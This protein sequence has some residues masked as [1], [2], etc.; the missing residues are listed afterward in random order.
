[1]QALK[2]IC[3]NLIGSNLS[4]SGGRLH[5]IGSRTVKEERQ[6]SEGAF[7]YVWCVRDVDTGEQFALKKMLCQD[8]ERYSLAKREISIMARL[9]K[10]PNIVEYYGSCTVISGKTREVMILMEYCPGGH[11]LN[12]L[13]RYGGK[14]SEVKLIK[15]FS[16]V[17]SG[18]FHLHSETP[19][20]AHRDMKVENV[21][22]GKE[23]IYKICDFGSVSTRVID[24]S[25]CTREDNMRI[26]ENIERSTT[27]MYR[28]PEMVDLYKKYELSEKVDIWM[29]GCILFTMAFYRHPFQDESSLAIA[30]ANFS[31]PSDHPYSRKIPALIHWTLSMDPRERPTAAE[32]LEVLSRYSDRPDIDIPQC[33]ARRRDQYEMKQ[34]E[35]EAAHRLPLGDVVLSSR[36]P[37]ALRDAA[38]PRRAAPRHLRA[39]AVTSAFSLG[40]V[41]QK[42]A[43]AD[44]SRD[45]DFD[46]SQPAP[47]T[48]AD[49]GKLARRRSPSSG[50]IIAS[51]FVLPNTSLRRSFLPSYLSTICAYA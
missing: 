36:P 11:L 24:T 34:A 5:V 12:L 45:K 50:I 17:C 14:L 39:A 23:G 41:S 7:A 30:N 10:H 18:V 38:E 47:P 6:L 35:T 27:M 33:V 9:P 8:S 15:V 43:G 21:L 26:E 32:L 3:N 37:N 2:S 48:T 20:I 31:I 25:Q 40:G 49:L 42:K 13:D 51:F 19:P 29:L 16:D 1:M 4:S 22:C 28:P 46:P 44:G